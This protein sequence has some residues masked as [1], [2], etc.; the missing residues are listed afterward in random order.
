[1]S[2]SF[3]EAKDTAIALEYLTEAKALLRQDDYSFKEVEE[4]LLKASKSTRHETYLELARLYEKHNMFDEALK[5]YV[6]KYNYTGLEG[7]DTVKVASWYEQG[8]GAEIDYNMAVKLY[9]KIAFINDEALK[10]AIRLYKDKSATYMR[11]LAPGLMT[12]D[13]WEDE[14]RKRG[15]IK[16]SQIDE[17]TLKKMSDDLRASFDKDDEL[18]K[19]LGKDKFS[20]GYIIAV[21]FYLFIAV[22]IGAAVSDFLEQIYEINN[23]HWLSVISIILLSAG[24]CS[25]VPVLAHSFLDI[26]G[27]RVITAIETGILGGALVPIFTGF[28]HMDGGISGVFLISTIMTLVEYKASIKEQLQRNE[29]S[30]RTD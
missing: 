3:T 1:M 5:W 2:Q 29:N 23:G 6:R 13:K 10:G 19:G 16:E 8:I 4:L 14:A 12:L 24:F 22:M 28:E 9:T 26:K 18:I 27:S 17:Q 11:T 21:I 25:F 15:V 30:K 7:E 20:P